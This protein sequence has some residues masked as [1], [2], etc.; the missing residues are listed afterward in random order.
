[1]G[2]S[3]KIKRAF[4]GQ[5]SLSGVLLE[6]AR[7]GGVANVLIGIVGAVIGGFITTHLFGDNRSNNGFIASFFVA[8]AGACLVIFAWKRLAVRRS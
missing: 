1:M 8:L 2:I 6:M 5:V 7:Q 4:R 3:Q